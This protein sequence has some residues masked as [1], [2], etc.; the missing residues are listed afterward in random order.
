MKLSYKKFKKLLIKLEDDEKVYEIKS[1]LEKI[2]NT[3]I[4]LNE[5]SVWRFPSDAGP[6]TPLIWACEF[7]FETI[8][9]LLLELGADPN[10]RDIQ[11]FSPLGSV[12]I[13]HSARDWLDSSTNF[14][15]EKLVQHGA[16][17]EFN[18]DELSHINHFEPKDYSAFEAIKLILSSF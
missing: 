17:A 9:K 2:I 7:R 16:K 3:G 5:P 13:G 11:G 15:V 18:S 14:I 8:V 4:N 10:V 1:D 6:T 12:L